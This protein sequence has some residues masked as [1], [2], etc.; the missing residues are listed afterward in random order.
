MTQLG[1][2]AATFG[3]LALIGGVFVLQYR[4]SLKERRRWMFVLPVFFLVL[5]VAVS[6]LVFAHGRQYE[7]REFTAQDSY[8]NTLEMTVKAPIHGNR[9]TLFSDLYVY[10]KD[11]ILLDEIFLAYKNGVMVKFGEG[12]GYGALID[13]MTRGLELDGNSMSQETVGKSIPFF[14]G[15]MGGNPF[16]ALSIPFGIPLV[17]LTLIGAVARIVQAKRL[18]WKSMNKIDILSISADK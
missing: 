12:D 13:R 5:Y 14:G 6:S 3:L 2:L 9:A 18:R 8:G 1:N 7:N 17:L 10:D 15:A 4:W 16:L 11:H